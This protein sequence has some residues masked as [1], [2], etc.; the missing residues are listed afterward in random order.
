MP[1]VVP[2]LS[3]VHS[4]HDH[5]AIDNGSGS[6]CGGAASKGHLPSAEPP[7]RGTV[8]RLEDSRST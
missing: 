5:N 6:C 1:R 2:R 8:L 3:H 7:P 4:I